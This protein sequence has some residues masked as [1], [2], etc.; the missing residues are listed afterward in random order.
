[1]WAR[2]INIGIGIW[3]MAAPAVLGY[4]GVASNHDRIVG[5][6][7]AS[8]ACIAL[9]EVTR[10]L[11]WVN[12]L[13]GG[14]MLLAPWILG[15]GPTATVNSLLAGAAVAGLSLVRGTLSHRFGGGWS[16]LWHSAPRRRFS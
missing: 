8:F 9:W 11:R 2:L 13:L 1:M 6:L 4:G 5:P 10:P 7:L 3:L 14:W 12:L 15:F 16:S